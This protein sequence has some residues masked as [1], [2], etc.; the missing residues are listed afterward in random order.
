MFIKSLTIENFRCF[1]NQPISFST[2]NKVNNGSGLNIFIGENSNGKTSVLEAVEYLT[3]SRLKTK[4]T[5]R[6]NDFLNTKKQIRIKAETEE[7]YVEK[8]FGSSK[9]KANGFIFLAKAR[10]KNAENF[11]SPIVFDNRVVPLDSTNVKDYDLRLDVVKPWAVSRLPSLGIF[12]FDKNR[13][14]HITKGM[15]PTRFEDVVS[16]LNFQVLEKI[17]SLD[18]DIS[19][20]LAKKQKILNINNYVK[21]AMKD[22]FSDKI[23]NK[24]VRDC[25]DFFDYEIS[26]DMVNN[27]EPFSS[28]FFASLQGE[29]QQQLPISRL[30]S[31]IEMIFSI[32]FLYHYYSIN[33][34][35]TIFLIDEPELHLHP[36]WQMKLVE[37]LMRISMTSQVFLSTHSPYI[38]KNCLIDK[39]GLYIFNK[40][41]NNKRVISDA[42]ESNWKHFP[43]SPSWGEINYY[44]YNL[45]TV[46]FHNELYGYVQELSKISNISDFDSYL[47]NSKKI[48]L[49]KKYKSNSRQEE[50]VTLCTYVRNQIHHPE[51]NYN[52]RFNDEELR[53]STEMLINCF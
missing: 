1:E 33:G 29:N 37:L 35:N 27:L 43:W 48:S 36:I 22:L 6:I 19:E 17:H 16:D 23:M 40:D 38:F 50:N 32:I 39:V 15:F 30:G 49:T 3:Q 42:R 51:N 5:I 47:K 44:A 52:S 11:L 46:E 12:F 26:L 25:K 2:P 31:G 9:F 13:T 8:A 10:E 34:I 14:R 21:D 28:S 24:V 53:K 4:N 18:E 20:E 45:P 7:F 41:E